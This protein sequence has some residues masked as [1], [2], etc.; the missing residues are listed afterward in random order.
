LSSDWRIP[1][2]ISIVAPRSFCPACEKQI[3]WF[4]NLPLIS[5][6]VLRKR[7]RNCGAAIS[8]RYPL[9][10]LANGLLFVAVYLYLLTAG[11]LYSGRLPF[12]LIPFFW[13]FGASLLA[14][15]MIDW[16]HFILPDRFTYPLL[17]FGFLLAALIPEHFGLFHWQ[18]TFPAG[19]VGGVWHALLGALIGGAGLWLIG[20]AGKAVFKKEAMGMGDVKMM[21]AVGA[22]QGWQVV[23]LSI[24]SGAF[25][26]SLAGITL[27]VIK[28][29]KWGSRIPF[30][31][32]LALGS[33]IT[34]FFGRR[35]L[36]WYLGFCIR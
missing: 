7:C 31:P 26:A 6:L 1:R 35:I 17:V 15:G 9:V 24:F 27:I 34:L 5:Y 25:L 21:A 11:R 20:I 23:L 13:Y 36:L 30:G 29:V 4:D 10:E 22:W 16:E 12:V 32:Y 8:S 18:G 19:R 2:R 14:L 28:K 33:L 3:A